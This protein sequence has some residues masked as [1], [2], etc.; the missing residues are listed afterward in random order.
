[1]DAEIL[2]YSSLA[3]GD[4]AFHLAVRWQSVDRPSIGVDEALGRGVDMRSGRDFN[5]F[6]KCFAGKR[7]ALLS[8]GRMCVNSGRGPRPM[9][10]G[11]KP[12]A[13]AAFARESGSSDVV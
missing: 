4:E 12:E 8:T 2:A 11:F 5:A 9:F 7:C 13:S 6:A 3:G 1:M 10:S